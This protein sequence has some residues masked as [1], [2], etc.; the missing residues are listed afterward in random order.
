MKESPIVWRRFA[1]GLTFIVFGIFFFGS[2]QGLLHRGFWLDALA[3]W[4][5]CLIALGLRLI[6]DRSKT[7]WAVVLSPLIIVATLSYVALRGSEPL[8]EDWRTV[9][10]ARGSQTE[11]WSL[12]LGVALAD[13]SLRAGSVAP[14]VLLE[15]RMAPSSHGSVRASSRGSGSRVYL[16]AGGWDTRQMVFRPGRRHRWELEVADDLPM[17]INLEGAFA[18]GELDLVSVEVT[19]VNL[20]GAFNNIVFFLGAPRSDV[21]VELEGAFNRVELVVPE[22]TPVSVSTD[23]FINLVDRRSDAQ[24]LS[25]PAYRVR[26]DGAF[27]RVVVR[28]EPR[29][30]SE[31]APQPESAP[32]Q[33]LEAE[34]EAESSV[35]SNGSLS[36]EDDG[37]P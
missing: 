11:H 32:E 33:V 34:V 5:V 19:D 31:P 24:S 16:R 36:P 23:G 30:E 10:A 13:L 7:P 20:Q 27:N 29:P 6:F 18:E 3:F 4:P 12:E 21:R 15:G 28:S 14:G 1:R 8:S 9:E 22:D 37:N 2:A 25:G 35:S 17:T 26:A